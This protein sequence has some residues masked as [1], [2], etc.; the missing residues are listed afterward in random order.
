MTILCGTDYSPSARAA[1]RAAAALA[2]RLR[3][4]LVLAHALDLPW[5]RIVAGLAAHEAERAPSAPADAACRE[6]LARSAAALSELGAEVTTELVEGA[7]DEALLALAAERG[8]RMIVVGSVGRRHARLWRLGSVAD[9]LAQGSGV[10]V[11]VVRDAAPFEAWR[12]G[13]RA[14]RVTLGLD[15]TVAS[16]AAQQWVASLRSAGACDVERVHVYTPELEAQR[17][18]VAPESI[19][20]RDVTRI[21]RDL[22]ADLDARF[23]ATLPGEG[24]LG[25]RLVRRDESEADLLVRAAEESHADLLVVGTHRRHG[26]NR[27]WHGSVS[28]RV[29]PL[30]AGNVACVPAPAAGAVQ[31]HSSVLAATDFSPLGDRAVA[32]AAALLP[33]GGRLRVVHV[34]ETPDVPSPL[35]AHYSESPGAGPERR[36]A[37]RVEAQRRLR[38]LVPSDLVAAG[39]EVEVSVVE[40]TDVARAIVDECERAGADVVCVG[41]HGSGASGHLGKNVERLFAHCEVPVLVVG[42]VQTG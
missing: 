20:A 24:A 1:E 17:A 10:P 9:R 41:A 13:V 4:P 6:A 7:P 23:G 31:G 42:H 28:Y 22:A 37:A 40:S 39:I 34:L 2:A 15:F 3:A 5:T 33:A 32:H 25:W 38:G 27:L 26:W 30:C 21:E 36:E 11:L 16:E 14:L 19:G 35:Y 12:S 18:G 29:L 8:A